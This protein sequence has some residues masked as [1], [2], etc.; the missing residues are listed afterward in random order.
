MYKT[1]KQNTKRTKACN[2]IELKERKSQDAHRHNDGKCR[3]QHKRLATQQMSVLNPRLFPLLI[4]FKWRKGFCICFVN[5]V[6]HFNHVFSVCRAVSLVNIYHFWVS[7]IFSWE[8]AS[9]RLFF[10]SFIRS[11]WN[12]VH[13]RNIVICITFLELKNCKLIFSA[14]WSSIMFVITVYVQRKVIVRQ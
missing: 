8:S 11:P 6:I 7:C 5:A 3:E 9:F 10:F 12:C 13:S 14:T 2:I 1:H 4:L